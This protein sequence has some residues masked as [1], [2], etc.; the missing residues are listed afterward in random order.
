MQVIMKEDVYNQDNDSVKHESRSQDTSES[1]KSVENVSHL[2]SGSAYR[3]SVKSTLPKI[4]S[5]FGRLMY[6]AARRDS[7]RDYYQSLAE[8]GAF[9][10]HEVDQVLRYEH[11]KS[12][13]AWLCLS[14]EGQAA[15]VTAYVREHLGNRIVD[16]RSWKQALPYSQLIPSTA[17]QAQRD[18]FRSDL[19]IVLSLLL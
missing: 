6:I 3:D 8:D 9:D 7:E 12:F 13:E 18:L 2:P 1:A 14:L 16:I 15:D 19:E 17:L 11:L 5:L 4:P 10:P